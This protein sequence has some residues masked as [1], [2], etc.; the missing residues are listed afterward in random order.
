M[1]A[2]ITGHIAVERDGR[3]RKNKINTRDTRDMN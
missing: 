1:S 3:G 2:Y